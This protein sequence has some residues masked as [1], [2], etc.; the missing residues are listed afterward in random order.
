VKIPTFKSIPLLGLFLLGLAIASRTL[1][2]QIGSLARSQWH[3]SGEA[4]TILLGFAS[5]SCVWLVWLCKSAT[6][7]ELAE[8]QWRAVWSAIAESSNLASVV[9]KIVTFARRLIWLPVYA[10]LL[11]I[12][13][14]AG[15][16]SLGCSFLYCGNYAAAES[17]FRVAQW[18]FYGS[19]ARSSC[20]VIDAPR[21]ADSGTDFMFDSQKRIEALTQVYGADSTQ[22]AHYY[23][24]LASSYLWSASRRISY[25]YDES[26]KFAH[27]SMQ[28]YVDNEDYEGAAS[29]LGIAALSKANRGDLRSANSLLVEAVRILPWHIG[30]SSNSSRLDELHFAAF[31]LG[32]QALIKVLDSKWHY[33]RVPK[34]KGSLDATSI[35]IIFPVYL[36]IGL[37]ASRER[38]ILT[39]L[40]SRRW[41]R[42]LACSSSSTEQIQLLDNLTT[43]YLFNRKLDRADSYSKLMLK[44]SMELV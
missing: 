3:F 41:R 22:M 5:L 42:Q 13:F 6:K 39:L 2:V 29:A 44:R 25:L 21:Y 15:I 19:N 10:I 36:L 33:T 12:S 23:E 11:F 14:D 17:I 24:V 43:L 9:C 28:I 27:M 34:R 1:F 40:F 35:A 32:D 20:L 8:R 16:R 4:L 7:R 31:M 18:P 26:E 37:L 38:T 30:N